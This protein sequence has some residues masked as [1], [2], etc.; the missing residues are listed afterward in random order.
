MSELAT[1]SA[2]IAPYLALA[3]SSLGT[4]VLTAAQQRITDRAVDAGE[5]FFQR[6]LGHG[7]D[8]IGGGT[9]PV[10][11]ADRAATLDGRLARLDDTERQALAE[12][13]AAWLAGPVTARDAAGFLSHLAPRLSGTTINSPTTYGDHSAAIGVV[14]G[15]VHL[16]GGTDTGAAS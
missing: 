11:D 7:A 1:V 5:G 16:G 4:S 12:A 2:E 10:L 6:L 15:T 14:H 3:A 9:E 13:L 8:R